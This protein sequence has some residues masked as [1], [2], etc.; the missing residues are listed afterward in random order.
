VRNASERASQTAGTKSRA[1]L[2][3]EPL[4]SGNKSVL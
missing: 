3:G 4:H 2:C 1:L